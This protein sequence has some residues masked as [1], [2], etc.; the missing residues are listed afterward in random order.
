MRLKLRRLND[1]CSRSRVVRDERGIAL[2][3]ALGIMLVLTIVLTSVIFLTASSARDAHRTNASQKAFSLAEAGINNA[4]AVL[5]ANY[6]GTTIYP[7]DA[8]LMTEAGCPC[9]STYATGS[10]VWSGSLMASTDPGWDWEWDLTATGSVQNPTGPS[11]SPISRKAT[12]VVPVGIPLTSSLDPSTSSLDWVYADH[13]ITF[14]QSVKVESPVFA[15]HD[16]T[17]TSTATISELIPASVT[18]KARV[19]HVAVVRNLTLLNPGNQIGHVESSPANLKYL[20]VHGTCV[21]QNEKTPHTPCDNGDG[22][23]AKDPIYADTNDNADPTGLVT[24]PEMTCCAPLSYA[25]PVDGVSHQASGSDPSIMAFW[26]SNAALGPKHLCATSSG[27]PPRF[28]KPASA[29]ADGADGSINQ[30]ATAGLQPF[31]LT[32]SPYSCVSANGNGKLSWDGTTLTIKG[33]IFIDGSLTSSSKKAVYSGQGAIIVSGTYLMTNGTALCVA[34]DS[35]NNCK[36]DYPWDPNTAG[37]F[38]FADGDFK[39]DLSLQQTNAYGSGVGIEIHA[40]QYQGGLFAANMVDASVTN[41]VVQGPMVSAYSD[42][43]AGQKGVLSFPALAFPS[44]GTDGFA[45]PLPLPQLLPPRRFGG[46]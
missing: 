35:S 14:G 27:T 21:T 44:S 30:S 42:V 13:D 43:S 22:T 29:G 5:N 33:Q 7:G 38:I 16:L 36:T 46:S 24:A 11:A 32:G 6:P 4:L 15:G 28:D 8:N 37:M 3:M 39:T 10:V 9:T 45:G 25:A 23:A 19:N 20:H 1:L 2:V 41:T 17:L 31:D 34:L 18:E 26:Y 12:A 40:G